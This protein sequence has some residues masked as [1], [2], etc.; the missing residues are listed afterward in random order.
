MSKAHEQIQR[1]QDR[2]AEASETSGSLTGLINLKDISRLLAAAHNLSWLC[3]KLGVGCIFF[4]YHTLS[5]HL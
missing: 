5:Q 4:L 1:V 3:E 2:Q